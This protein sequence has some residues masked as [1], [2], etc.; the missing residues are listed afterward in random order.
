MEFAVIKAVVTGNLSFPPSMALKSGLSVVTM[1]SG[2]SA[3]PEGPIVEIGSVLGSS[4]ARYAAVASA[5]RRSSGGEAGLRPYSM[6][7]GGGCPEPYFGNSRS[8]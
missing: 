2:G 7:L 8:R 3:G 1:A 4:I 5:Q 6:R